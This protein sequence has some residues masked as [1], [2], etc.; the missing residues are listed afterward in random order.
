MLTRFGGPEVFALGEMAD[1]V[2]GPDS[3]IVDVTLAGVNHADLR[4][5]R[6][7]HGSPALPAVLGADVVGHR[8]SD[9]RRVAAL[10]TA[11]GG[12]AQV[13]A[14]LRRHTVE[15]PDQVTDEQALAVL[16]QGLTAWHSLHTLGRVGDGDVVVV[17]A[18]AGG[19]GHLAVQLARWAGARVVALASTPSKRAATLELGAHAAVDSRHPDLAAAV[20]AALGEAPTLVLDGVGGRTFEQLRASLAPFGR[21]VAYGR[22]G[23]DVRDTVTVD[24][25]MTSS[26]GVLGFWLHRVL[27]DE[28]LYRSSAVRLLHLAGRGV[29]RAWI[30]GR[31]P[32]PS[33]AAAHADLESRYTAGKLVIDVRRL[34]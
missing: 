31:Y 25:L 2:P 12:Y 9:G 24:D 3:E 27:D 6:G 1:P 15:V 23:D 20:R 21:I 33:V 14:P 34:S 10:L 18:G 8:R 29:L 5:R 4:R 13:A 17:T 16:E 30:G 26:T 7:G 22:A 28:E 32:L 11:G 19:V